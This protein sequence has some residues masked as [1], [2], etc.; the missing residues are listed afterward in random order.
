MSHVPP[1]IPESEGDLNRVV[2]LLALRMQST[3]DK[4]QRAEIKELVGSYPTPAQAVVWKQAIKR[5]IAHLV[6][7]G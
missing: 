3:L 1:K 7:L 5:M 2:Q 6:V 4:N